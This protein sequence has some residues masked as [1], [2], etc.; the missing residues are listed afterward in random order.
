MGVKRECS[1]P[2]GVGDGHVAPVAAPLFLFSVLIAAVV[3]VTL[4]TGV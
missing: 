3:L 2:A 1:L 4:V